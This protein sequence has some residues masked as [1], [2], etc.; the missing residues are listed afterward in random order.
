MI[1]QATNIPT[2]R[3]IIWGRKFCGLET[4]IAKMPKLIVVIQKMH[5]LSQSLQSC[6]CEKYLIIRTLKKIRLI[7]IATRTKK[8]EER[9]KMRKSVIVNNPIIMDM[10]AMTF[11]VTLISFLKQNC[12]YGVSVSLLMLNK[13]FFVS[14]INLANSYVSTSHLFERQIF[15][16][17][18]CSSVCFVQVR[19]FWVP[20]FLVK[21]RSYH[22]F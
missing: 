19:F 21:I 5:N 15:R 14:L 13:I 16:K 11:L 17:P 9:W 22:H 4:L 12:L 10:K 2:S 6:R 20:A 18:S 7:R 8:I 1:K 3:I